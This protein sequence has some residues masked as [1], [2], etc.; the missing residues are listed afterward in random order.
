MV[1]LVKSPS[2]EC[3]S[4]SLMI[5]QHWIRWCLHAI[6][7]LWPYD[8]TRPQWVNTSKA[9]CYFLCC[10]LIRINVKNNKK[11]HL[12]DSPRTICRW[13]GWYIWFYIG[14]HCLQPPLACP[15]NYGVHVLMVKV[16]IINKTCIIPVALFSVYQ[17]ICTLCLCLF[18]C[19]ELPTSGKSYVLHDN[20]FHSV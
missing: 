11:L 6:R 18:H 1:F 8:I 7:S 3:H 12:N 16:K 19:I 10:H 15:V 20:Q 17:V 5:S 14:V 2:D 4:T 13:V 9:T